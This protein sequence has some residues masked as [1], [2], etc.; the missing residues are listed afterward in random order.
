VAAS[1][2]SSLTHPAMMAGNGGRGLLGVLK[3][4]S[5]LQFY[6]PIW[7]RGTEGFGDWTAGSGRVITLILLCIHIA[8]L[9]TLTHAS[10]DG[11]AV[12]DMGL[13]GLPFD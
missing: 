4:F 7:R 5:L 6:A 13:W 8:I 3:D 10:E 2:F 11:I 9:I 12:S 1:K